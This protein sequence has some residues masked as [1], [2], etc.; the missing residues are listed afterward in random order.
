MDASVPPDD[1]EFCA[2]L[3]VAA[4]LWHRWQARCIRRGEP[5]EACFEA[6]LQAA[7]AGVFLELLNADELEDANG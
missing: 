6:L 2:V 1:H 4:P 3:A 5:P 7:A